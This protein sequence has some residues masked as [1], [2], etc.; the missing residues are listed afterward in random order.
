MENY[1][2]SG[3]VQADVQ[4]AAETLD[5]LLSQDDGALLATIA[6]YKTSI[7]ELF[8]REGVVDLLKVAIDNATNVEYFSRR[9]RREID[10]ARPEVNLKVDHLKALSENVD[11]KARFA[12]RGDVNTDK[13]LMV[14]LK[15]AVIHEQVCIPLATALMEKLG[16]YWAKAKSH[17]TDTYSKQASESLSLMV[18]TIFSVRISEETVSSGDRMCSLTMFL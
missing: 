18:C 6:R 2:E 13:K 9:S 10:S 3:I 14:E 15:A 7:L 4:T 5:A 1:M 8:G 12:G 17:V 11:L 16:P